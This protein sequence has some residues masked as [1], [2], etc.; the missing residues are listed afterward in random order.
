M[1]TDVSNFSHNL[2]STDTTVQQRRWNTLDDST[3]FRGDWAA[4]TYPAGD[5]VLREGIDYISLVNNN[6]EVPRPG[7]V[8]WSGLAA[9][10]TYRGTA[11][12]VSSNYN[13][14]HLGVRSR[15]GQLLGFHV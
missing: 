1:A 15:Y 12:T 5:I 8:N 14:G 7:A 3:P 11:P 6:Q 10:Y 13:F 4:G 2:S 9:G